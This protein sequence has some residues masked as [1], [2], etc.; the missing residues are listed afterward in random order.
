M[1]ITS[2]RPLPA[3]SSG[4]V[5]RAQQTPHF[6]HF[7]NINQFGSLLI[8]GVL[9]PLVVHE[10]VR[11]Q[12]L[13]KQDSPVSGALSAAGAS[14][15][16]LQKLQPGLASRMQRRRGG[17]T[18]YMVLPAVTVFSAAEARCATEPAPHSHTALLDWARQCTHLPTRPQ[19][20]PDINSI[21]EDD[22]V[23]LLGQ[24]PTHS[25]TV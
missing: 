8:P 7:D 16:P 17:E 11:V 20:T 5:C 14:F 23:E 18:M 12:H 21:F 9:F 6:N 2:R 19:D 10:P 3:Q 22:L 15:S 13:A 25:M 24:S 4:P 1:E